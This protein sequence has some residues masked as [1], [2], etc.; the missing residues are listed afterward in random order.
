MA[1]K[2]SRKTLISLAA[3]GASLS[4][5]KPAS[6]LARDVTDWPVINGA[7]AMIATT[8]KLVS[9]ARAIVKAHHD[10]KPINGEIADT[11]G[12]VEGLLRYMADEIEYYRHASTTAFPDPPSSGHKHKRPYGEPPN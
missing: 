10:N 8:T 6:A 7:S 11:W 2:I 1:T 4:F 12:E 9:A 3:A 5:V